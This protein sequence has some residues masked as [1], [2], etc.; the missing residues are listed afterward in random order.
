[1]VTA[2]TAGTATASLTLPPALSTPPTMSTINNADSSSSR[3]NNRQHR[4]HQSTP[5]SLGVP[6]LIT[7]PPHPRRATT[8]TGLSKWYYPVELG[9]RLH[10]CPSNASTQKTDFPEIDDCWSS[11]WYPHC[12]W[13]GSCCHT[14]PHQGL[15]DHVGPRSTTALWWAAQ[16]DPRQ[17]CCHHHRACTPLCNLLF[18]V[19]CCL[20]TML[21][22]NVA[23]ACEGDSPCPWSLAVGQQSCCQWAL[24]TI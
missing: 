6:K 19:A 22:R 7:H 15:S 14:R 11:V 4:P 23:P 9:T 5:N 24:A 1:M 16:M 10:P 18:R 20:L 13:V 3:N 8:P 21:D 12:T 17:P 2:T